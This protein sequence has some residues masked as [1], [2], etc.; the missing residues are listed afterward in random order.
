MKKEE[1]VIEDGTVS[2]FYGEQVPSGF[3]WVLLDVQENKN[4]F[5]DTAYLVSQWQ[6]AILVG[7]S[8]VYKR[9]PKRAPAEGSCFAV[10]GAPRHYSLKLKCFYSFE[11]AEKFVA[12][13]KTDAGWEVD[14]DWTWMTEKYLSNVEFIQEKK[15]R[16]LTID[17]IW[18]DETYKINPKSWDFKAHT[19][20][21]NEPTEQQ[22]IA[23]RQVDLN[24]AKISKLEKEL[25]DL[26]E[27]QKLLKGLR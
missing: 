10:P 18:F 24:K 17:R 7:G 1:I 6:G 2:W 26:R 23:Q 9:S 22:R 25:K 13:G 21:F 19:N 27:L 3:Y 15:I 5:T 8:D 20:P 12:S 16:G 4:R 14:Y 11:E